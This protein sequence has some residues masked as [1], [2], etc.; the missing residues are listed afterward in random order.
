MA[1]QRKRH[2]ESDVQATPTQEQENRKKQKKFETNLEEDS[3]TLERE[4]Q[5]ERKYLQKLKKQKK[6]IA[7]LR[8]L[9]KEKTEIIKKLEK[10]TDVPEI[11][12]KEK[13]TP[14]KECVFECKDASLKKNPQTILVKG[15]NC[16]FPRDEIKSALRKHFSSCGP[17]TAIF[18]PFHCKTG[19]PMGYA[20]I[21]MG[22]EAEKALKLNRSCLEGQ[23]L[24]VSMAIKSEEYGGYRDLHGCERC[25]KA[26]MKRVIERFHNSFGFRPPSD[27]RKS[28]FPRKSAARGIANIHG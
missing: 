13:E 18:I 12:L 14:N 19:R 25:H 7:E 3:D 17:V 24:S 15:F 8:N 9:L 16:S 1:D 26:H 11:S 4:K 21:N 2:K 5:Q 20:F 27:V 6:K 22:Q 23:I 28:L 10:K